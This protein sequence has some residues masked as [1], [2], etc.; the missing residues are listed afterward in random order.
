MTSPPGRRGFLFG[1]LL[2]ASACYGLAVFLAV[3]P[4][5]AAPAPAGQVPSYMT[6]KGL[7][8]HGPFRAMAALI[9]LPGLFALAGR[10]LAV[11]F[12]AR[13]AAPWAGWTAAGFLFAALW[14]ELLHPTGAALLIGTASIAAGLLIIRRVAVSFTALDALLIPAFVVVYFALLDLRPGVQYPKA[15]LASLG[16]VLFLRVVLGRMERP[17]QMPAAWCF[18]LVPAAHVLQIQLFQ[19]D[20][21]WPSVLALA[22]ALGSPLVLRLLVPWGKA[23]AT[24]ARRFRA[25]LIYVTLPLFAL[26]YPSSRTLTGYEGA[27][28]VNFFEDGHQLLPA[29]EMLRGE[30]LYRDVVPG[31]GMIADGGL[32]WLAMRLW[33]ARIDVALAARHAVS[34]L[35][36][37]AVYALGLAATGSPPAALLTMLFSSQMISFG[38]PWL[39]SAPAFAA[40]AFAMAAARRREP[41]RFAGAGVFLVLSLLTSV[42]M[43]IYTGAALLLAVIRFGD[44]RARWQALRWS[45]IGASAV[46]LPAALFFLVRGVLDDLLRVTVFEVL[47]LGPAY[48]LGFDWA[49]PALRSHAILPEALLTLF[50]PAVFEF[51]LWIVIVVVTAAGLAASPLRGQRRTEPLWLL[52]GWVALAGLSFAERHHDYFIY[53]LAPFLAIATFFLWRGRSAAARACGA[54]ALVVLVAVS[55]PTEYFGIA[56]WLRSGPAPRPADW[57][58]V[59]SLPRARG[60]LFPRD[61]AA[62]LEAARVFVQT[63]LRPGETFYDFVNLPILYFLLDR[64]C[65]IRQ[66]EVPFYESEEGQREVIARLEN[67]RSVRAVL[68]EFQTFSGGPIDGVP[69]AQRVPLVWDWLQKHFRPSY[70]RDGVVFWVRTVG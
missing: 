37:V 65:P 63:A 70:A 41:R 13:D 47:S 58:E 59:T 31:H 48:A 60:A 46:G 38:L 27:F 21:V 4:Q 64:P 35:N 23:D 52:G 42:E 54:V 1:L 45:T 39:R 36:A 62:K 29:S 69:N 57:V 56:A 67:D 20:R 17:G 15:V 6:A 34:S 33:G 2:V 18:S 24:A 7:D 32:D 12:A 11:R 61:E 50:D 40:L 16:V 19:R 53:G 22:I 14:A 55:R 5:F 49:P 44:G 26:A 28:R 66:Y 30:R 68:M 25:V 43:G 9:L 8:A 3:F 51:L 10:P